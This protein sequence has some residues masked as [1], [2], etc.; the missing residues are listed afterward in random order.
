MTHEQHDAVKQK[1]F[2]QLMQYIQSKPNRA[3]KII[4]GFW[5]MTVGT[6]GD[7]AFRAPKFKAVN[8]NAT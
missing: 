3:P 1:G 5:P 6:I 4:R 8:D 7:S 2:L